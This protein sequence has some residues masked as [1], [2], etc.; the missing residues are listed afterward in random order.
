MSKVEIEF[1]PATDPPDVD[2]NVILCTEEECFQGYYDD[3]HNP[4]WIDSTGLQVEGVIAWAHLPDPKECVPNAMGAPE[5]ARAGRV[6]GI[7][8]H[9]GAKASGDSFVCDSCYSKYTP[10]MLT[11]MEP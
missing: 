1:Y 9:C 3:S 2:T 6:P 8:M 11:D 5:D 10:G 7:C 4:P